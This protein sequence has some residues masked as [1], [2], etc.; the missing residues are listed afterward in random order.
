[1]RHHFI[2]YVEF[3]AVNI[4]A[5]QRFFEATFAWV[6]TAYGPD[7]VA[8]EHA[9]VTG[10]FYRSD[11]KS[12]SSKGGALVVLYSDNLEATLQQVVANGGLV[13]KEIFSFPG[14]RRFQFTEPS[15][16]ELAVWTEQ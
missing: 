6:F 1:M 12:E 5:T 2:D 9:G 10:G 13:V 11:L 3:P 16:N 14:G 15:G 7:Y 4:D 8:F